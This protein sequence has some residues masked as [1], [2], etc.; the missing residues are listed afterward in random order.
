[1]NKE[2]V[3]QELKKPIPVE[4]IKF[5]AFQTNKEKHI[6]KF[7]P[8]VRKDTIIKRLDDVAGPN[9]SDEYKVYPD[10][11]L[12]GVVCDLHVACDDGV[13]SRQG[14]DCQINIQEKLGQNFSLSSSATKSFGKAA[15]ML[16]IGRELFGLQTGWLECDDWGNPTKQI[17]LADCSERQQGSGAPSTPGQQPARSGGGSF[18]E[19]PIDTSKD[20][21]SHLF[22][23]GK[24][25]GKTLGQM[26]EE[27]PDYF[28]WAFTERN[29]LQANPFG[30]KFDSGLYVLLRAGYLAAQKNDTTN[31]WIGDSDDLGALVLVGKQ[32][33]VSREQVFGLLKTK[34][35]IGID[36]ATKSV[37]P[38]DI[39]DFGKMRADILQ[40][41]QGGVV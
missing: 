40:L 33:G 25:K 21:F 13:I 5:R 24:Y 18:R 4:E 34:Y 16:G 10:G 6:A 23:F 17:T 41:P 2:E 3:Y 38:F 32:A 7:V 8:Y 30:D 35:N 12:V 1:M 19:Y 28:T 26:V 20:I 27:A 9:W 14:A 11:Q 22:P 29:L 31:V 15:E 37:T 36:P 39:T